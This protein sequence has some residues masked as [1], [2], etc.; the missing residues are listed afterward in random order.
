MSATAQGLLAPDR[1]SRAHGITTSIPPIKMLIVAIDAAM[2]E[3]LC[4]WLQEHRQ[5]Y[6]LVSAGD[7][8][9]ALTKDALLSEIGMAIGTMMDGSCNISP[10]IDSN[11]ADNEMPLVRLTSR[12]QEVVE[13]IV[14]GKKSREISELL[15]IS[16]RTVDTHRKHIMDKWQLPNTAALVSFAMRN[17][18]RK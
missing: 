15:G 13:L 10:W 4:S 6:V 1:S 7:G 16:C 17:G 2:S 18:I 14:Q 8:I 5:L 3:Q 9:L 11:S 12:E